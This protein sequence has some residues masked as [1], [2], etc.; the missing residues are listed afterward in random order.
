L[1]ASKALVSDGT[2][3]VAVSGTTAV[4]LGYSSGVSS[5]IQTQLDSKIGANGGAI[6]GLLELQE[7]TEVFNAKTGATGVVAHDFT[8]GTIF[9]HTSMAADFTCNLTGVPTTANRVLAV[10]LVLVQGATARMCTALQIAGS[11]QTI[12]W[13]GGAVPTGT[14]SGINV[15]TFSLIATATNVFT[16]LGQNVSFA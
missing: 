16:V 14:A 5:G 3:K 10:T 12:K 7:I 15:V 13:Q 11:A 9:Y 6:A 4:E 8:T 1:T 2:G